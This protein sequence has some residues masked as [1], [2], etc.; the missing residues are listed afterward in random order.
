MP[1][2]A[3]FVTETSVR[4]VPYQFRLQKSLSAKNSSTKRA[5]ATF[6]LSLMQVI[7]TGGNI[8]VPCEI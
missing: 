8:I 7:K 6:L 1:F 3:E 4:H 2:D 5:F